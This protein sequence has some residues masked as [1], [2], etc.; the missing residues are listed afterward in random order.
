[1][2]LQKLYYLNP[3]ICKVEILSTLNV[4]TL[5]LTTDGN[6]MAVE[7]R[8]GKDW[9]PIYSTPGKNTFEEELIDDQ[10]NAYFQQKLE[11]MYPGEDLASQAALCNVSN[12]RLLVKFTYSSGLTKVFGDLKNPVV[13][14]I[15]FSTEKGGRVVT[16]SRKSEVPALNFVF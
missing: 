1:M 8:T 2:S 11:I 10:V 13:S 5:S 4:A 14:K 9:I 16:F 6:S 12:W 7:P 15:H 3:Q